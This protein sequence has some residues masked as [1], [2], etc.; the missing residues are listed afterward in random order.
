MFSWLAAVLAWM[1]A[2]GFDPQTLIAG[3]LGGVV[4]SLVS[5]SGTMTERILGCF[6]GCAFSVYFGPTLAAAVT[7]FPYPTACF[8][9]GL[10]GM[11][12]AEALVNLAKMYAR[13]PGAFRDLLLKILSKDSDDK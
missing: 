8:V 5:R 7:I 9:A 6:A 1:S 10:L 2:H 4:R 13:R 3:L 12:F 11:S